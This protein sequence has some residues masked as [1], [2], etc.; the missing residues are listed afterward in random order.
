LDKPKEADINKTI[1]TTLVAA[2]TLTGGCTS[3]GGGVGVG[4]DDG[5]FGYHDRND[6]HC[7]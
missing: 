1:I 6:V 7:C 5:C 4:Y 2:T 3:Y